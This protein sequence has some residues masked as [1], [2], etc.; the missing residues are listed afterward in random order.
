MRKPTGLAMFTFG[1]VLATA[2]CFGG[3][4]AVYGQTGTA[5]T[6]SAATPTTAPSL[7]QLQADRLKFATE[8][9][10]MT[11]A[12]FNAGT[13]D[14]AKVSAAMRLVLESR[15][16]MAETKTQRLEAAQTL[17]STCED[18]VKEVENRVRAG[19]LTPSELSYA[20]YDLADVR[21]RLAKIQ[22]EP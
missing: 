3:M 19:V 11:K 1:I 21:V 22:A 5:T 4:V 9:L 10:E 6:V 20:K 7:K 17:E 8:M 12:Q 14:F 18:Q 2:V 15:L 13:G 16:D